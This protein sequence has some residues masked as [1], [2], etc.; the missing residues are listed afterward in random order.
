MLRQVT[1]ECAEDHAI[2]CGHVLGTEKET[3]CGRHHSE[4]TSHGEEH[5]AHKDSIGVSSNFNTPNKDV[6][7]A[8]EGERPEEKHAGDGKL[9]E[10]IYNKQLRETQSISV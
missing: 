7:E 8:E 4:D 3:S 2:V 10:T 5:K 1:Y 6:G 9:K